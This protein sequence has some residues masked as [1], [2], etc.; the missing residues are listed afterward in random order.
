MFF[1]IMLPSA[2]RSCIFN[3]AQKHREKFSDLT[4]HEYLETMQ[5]AQRL[6]S[7]YKEKGFR[8][9]IFNKSGHRA[10]QTVPHWHEHLIFTSTKTQEFLGKLAIFKSML[11]GS[12]P[13]S[14][15]QLSGK[16][17]KIREELQDITQESGMLS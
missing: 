5:F 13:L 11:I 7:F 12:S 15:Q 14:A 4:L 17:F 2:G 1:I 16:I 8:A 3:H 10:G 9:H 6:V